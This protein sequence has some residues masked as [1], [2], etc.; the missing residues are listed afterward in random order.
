MPQTQLNA[1][2][3]ICPAHVEAEEIE[4]AR[5]PADALHFDGPLTS[6]SSDRMTNGVDGDDTTS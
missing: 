4:R 6:P 3:S 5:L 1:Q 2:P